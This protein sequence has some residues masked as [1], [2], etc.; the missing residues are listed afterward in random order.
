MRVGGGWWIK[1]LLDQIAQAER[2]W[3]LALEEADRYSSLELEQERW[4]ART[5][6]LGTA[7][8]E[9]RRE[10]RSL[11]TRLEWCAERQRAAEQMAA[12]ERVDA[13][14]TDPEARLAALNAQL[15]AARAVVRRLEQEQSARD[16]LRE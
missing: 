9:M 11:E 13:F 4:T 10:L 3:K 2:R 12:L 14:P 7:E 16:L 1:E 8:Q 5:A 15:A 6:E